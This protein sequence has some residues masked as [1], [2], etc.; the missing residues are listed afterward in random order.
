MKEY[1]VI[2]QVIG[3]GQ[4]EM[5]T[6]AG[7]R[8]DAIR[9]VEYIRRGKVKSARLVNRKKGTAPPP[10]TA[11]TGI[12]Y[13]MQEAEA[14]VKANAHSGRAIGQFLRL[15]L[16]YAISDKEIRRACEWIVR[17]VEDRDAKK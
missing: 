1:K 16:S 6:Y 14:M 17:Q 8:A 9:F 3:G 15:K 12:D 2:Y 4:A 11:A 5:L 13:M 7:N 10:V